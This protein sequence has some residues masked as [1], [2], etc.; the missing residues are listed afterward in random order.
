MC[1]LVTGVGLP[2][3]ETLPLQKPVILEC[4]NSPHGLGGAESFRIIQDVPWVLKVVLLEEIWKS[5]K[6]KGESAAWHTSYLETLIQAHKNLKVEADYVAQHGTTDPHWMLHVQRLISPDCGA[7]IELPEGLQMVISPLR[8]IHTEE[9]SSID[10]MYSEYKM[11]GG[12]KGPQGRYN[13][14]LVSRTIWKDCIYAQGPEKSRLTTTLK[15]RGEDGAFQVQVGKFAFGPSWGT[16]GRIRLLTE[17][18]DPV[19]L[20]QTQ[21]NGSTSVLTT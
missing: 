20:Q 7:G 3:G 18:L 11:T 21:V 2:K 5:L 17:A 16:C 10:L 9:K 14:S 4:H 13:Q 15:I 19:L 12:K 6:V 8:A 1:H